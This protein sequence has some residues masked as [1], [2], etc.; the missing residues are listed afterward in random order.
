VISRRHFTR[1]IFGLPLLSF[2]PFRVSEV[3]AESSI[4]AKGKTIGE[5]FAGEELH[6]EIS[7]M[8]LK[9][10]GVAK[11]MFR[12]AQ[13]KGRYI[14]VLQGETLGVVGWLTKYRTDTYR[15]VMEEI[16]SGKR[17][18]SIS[19]EENVKIGKKTRVYSHE[20]DYQKRKWSKRSTRR[21]VRTR[22]SESVIPE[23]KTYDDFLCASYNFRHGVYGTIER[24]KTFVV[25]TFPR[26]GS[27]SYDIKIAPKA[28]EER[29]RV[30]DKVSEMAEYLIKLK[31]DPE[32]T[33][34][35]TG[36]IEGWLSK[37][38]YPV[39]GII[40]DV[41]LFGDVHGKLVKRAKQ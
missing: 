14:A 15:S 11:M 22:A 8:F 37:D 40:K 31:L 35:K 5:F 13:Q 39:E 9:K 16:D 10:V 1:W 21:G 27:S 38:I 6:Y 25:P 34:S 4:E 32:I 3:Y 29:M 18:R 36:L 20:F 19:F 24:G 41:I 33:D 23:G 2:S 7:F 30:V 12:P 28:E 26:K 17:L